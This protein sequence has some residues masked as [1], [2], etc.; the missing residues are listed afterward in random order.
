MNADELNEL[1]ALYAAATP[2]PWQ[3]Y[4]WAGAKSKA[5]VD[6]ANARSSDPYVAVCWR[7]DADAALIAAAVN[8]LPDLIAA[9]RAE[10]RT[11]TTGEPQ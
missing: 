5:T 11:D 2:G 1:E 3:S 4:R 9:A 8:A 10:A 7:N 6:P